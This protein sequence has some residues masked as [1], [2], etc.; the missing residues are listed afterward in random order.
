LIIGGITACTGLDQLSKWIARGALTGAPT[1]SF[2]HDC[3]RLQYVENR[4]GF[5]SLGESLSPALRFFIFIGLTGVFI[6]AAVI[7]LGRRNALPLSVTFPWI[8]VIG[9]AVGNQIDRIF[10]NGRVSDFLNVG[11]G[12]LRTGIFN[13]A[14]LFLT[15]GVVWLLF[16][17]LT[18]KNRSG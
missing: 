14:D 4:G 10:R 11:I 8:L 17:P 1:R 13:L 3:V 12:P 5:L 7:Y 2:W 6:L 15:I 16:I 18:Q 9:G